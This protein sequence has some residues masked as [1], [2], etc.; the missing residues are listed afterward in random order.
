MLRSMTGYGRAEASSALGLIIVEVQSINRKFLELSLYSLREFSRFDTE[1]RKMLTD[2]LNRGQVQLKIQIV[3]NKKT[4]ELNYQLLQNLKAEWVK[5]AKRLSYD[6]EE[7]TLSFLSDQ[8]KSSSIYDLNK[9]DLEAVKEVLFQTVQKALKNLIHM[10]EKEGQVLK[11]DLTKRLALLEKGLKE[12]EKRIPEQKK[13][14][15][16]KLH[17]TLDKFFQDKNESYERIAREM[18]LFVEKTDVTEEI[19]RFKS[20]LSQMKELMN[21]TEKAKGRKMDFIIQEIQREASTLAAKSS[22]PKILTLSIDMRS[23]IDQIKEQ[24]QNIE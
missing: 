9:T 14:H 15:E 5:I 19:V 20:H 16:T 18:A 23:L 6:S 8:A 13:S 11:E 12:V 22:D 17:A 21:N 1:I 7:V 2:E 24:N 3:P 4:Y 10:K